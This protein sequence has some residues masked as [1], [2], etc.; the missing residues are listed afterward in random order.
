[1]NQALRHRASQLGVETGYLDVDGRY[2][3]TP[4]P[5][6][7]RVVEVLE[8]DRSNGDE[9]DPIVVVGGPTAAD[10]QLAVGAVPWAEVVLADGTTIRLPAH[11]GRVTVSPDLP[12]GCHELRVS[13]RTT[14]LVV[15][16][17]AMPR[18]DHLTGRAGLFAPA[19]ALW[20]REAPLPSFAHLADLASRL[21][22]L[23]L[24]VL[25]TL[26]LY[27]GFLDDPFDP[28]PYAP[29]SRL[30]WNEVYLDDATLPVAERPVVGEL[31]D[32]RVLARRRR[33]QLL[34][35][36]RQLDPAA[37]AALDEYVRTHPD[38]AD[39]ARFRVARRDPVDAEAPSALVE[40]SHVLAQQLAAEQL[41]RIEG[42]GRT[43]LALDLPIGSH[44]AG[45][46]TWAHGELFA[47]GMSVGAPPDALF[48][49]GQD[50]G[51][52]PQLPGAGRRSGHL[53]WRRLVERAGEHAS[54]LRIDHVLGVQRLW[55]IPEGAAPTEGTYVR[56]RRDEIL[57]VIAAAAG[58][59]AT[60][61]VGEDLGTVP[62]GFRQAFAEWDALGLY[63]EQLHLGE[64][65]LRPI[66]ARSVAGARTHDMAPFAAAIAA[67]AAAEP[68][69]V[70]QYRCLLAAAL[71][72]AVA[73]D[74]AA[75]FDALLERLAHSS[76]YL[77]LADVDDLRGGVDPH[78]VPGRVLPTSWR[79]RWPVPISDMLCGDVRRR[80]RLLVRRSAR[81]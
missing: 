29:V 35:A 45:F 27:A 52:P 5:T 44:L 13:D 78:N 68:A 2:H 18:A 80:A 9:R 10:G 64:D 58:A 32:W 6:L 69:T 71:G 21:P 33:R 15:A 30:H 8:D 36:V 49:G 16:P 4:E 42:P 37:E 12:T 3:D 73:A 81:S 77:V 47:S 31:V 50:W 66:P 75:L 61:I 26:P 28:S 23:G 11:H 19:Y 62:E 59:T 72:R 60:T 24:D 34:D 70:E 38:V 1:V 67:L 57:A 39:Y 20:T 56:Y 63:E 17:P 48:A 54:V 51:F 14:T 7:R 41:G 74:P 65:Q 46:E 79:R 43:A 55:W 25:A 53:L 76:A 22:G 40:R